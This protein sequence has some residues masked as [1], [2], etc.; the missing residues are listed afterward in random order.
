MRKNI[1]L[2]ILLSFIHSVTALSQ[3]ISSEIH[4]KGLVKESGENGIFTE[5]L[6]F[7]GAFTDI[8]TQLPLYTESISIGSYNSEINASFDSV[9][10][11]PCSAEESNYL[12]GI[13]FRDRDITINTFVVVDRKVPLGII[14]FLP[15][16]FNNENGN[17][18]KLIFYRIKI[19]VTA[20]SNYPVVKSRNYA[21]HSVLSS[22]QW[23]KIKTGKSGIY[24][25]GYNDL[26]SFG[27]DP[28]SVNPTMIR[29]FGNGG[30]MLPEA[31][32]KFRY[33]DLQE[34]AIQVIGE[35]DGVFNQGDYI[36]FYGMDPNVWQNVLGYF[37]YYVNYYDD[38]N[39]YYLT[40]S[41]EPGKRLQTV[42]SVASN[43]SNYVTKYNDY[44]VVEDEEINLIQSGKV[45]YGDVFGE[46]NNRE[47]QFNFP[48]IV[49]SDPVIIKTEVANRSFENELMALH[50]N[51]DLN[52]T[53]ILTL[54]SPSSTK[55]AQKKKKT[56]TYYTGNTDVNVKFEYLPST[57]SSIAWLNYIMV[58]ASSN[59]KFD[60]GQLMFRQLSSVLDGAVSEFTITNSNPG[61]MVWDITNPII[62]FK[63]EPE[64][65]AGELLFTVQTDSLREFVAFDGSEYYS[66]EFVE[67]VD[68]QDLHGDGP[69]D[70][71]I[72]SHPLFIDQANELAALH[73][74]RDSF[75]I[76]VVGT[77][78]IYNEFSS[79]KQDP[80]AIRD[81]MK[82]LYD[83]YEGNEP[84]F[85]VLFGDGSFDPKNRYENNSNFIPAFQNEESWITASSFVI[86]DFYGFLDENEGNDGVGQL[87]I[88]IGRFP[89]QT[90]EEAQTAIDK[91]NLYLA[92][93]EPVFGTWRSKICFIADDEDGN[94]HLE[95]ADSLANGAGFIPELYNEQK[96]YLDAYPQVKTPAGYRYPA[97]TEAINNAVNNGALI[98]NYVGHGGKAGWAHE[99]I[100][101]SNDI[102]DWTNV[103][104]MP[105]FITATCEFTRFDEPELS[106]GGEMVFLNP[107]GGGIALFTTT[108]L[109]YAQS[110]FTVNQRVLDAAFNLTDGEHPYLGDIIKHSKPP[111]QLTTR[112]FILVGDPALKMAYSTYNVRTVKILNKSTQMASDTLQ[113]L[114][115]I[116]AEGE[117]IDEAGNKITNFNGK[118]YITLYDKPTRYN[119]IG[120]DTYSY[121]I[122][123][124][125]QDK[126]IWTGEAT[127]T[128]GSFVFTFMM[129]K[130]I[131][132]EYGS[133]K[134]S[135]YSFSNDADAM[136]YN[137]EIIIGGINTN[138]VSDNEGPQ[139]DLFLN[140]LTFV[141]GDQTHENPIML[142]FI[143]DLSGINLSAGGIGHEILATL[144]NDYSNVIYLSEYYVQDIDSYQSGKIYYPFYNLPDGLHT[145]TL[146]AWDNYNNPAEKTIEFL[147]NQNAVLALNQVKNSPNPFKDQTTFSFDHNNPGDELDI[148]LDIFDL[149]G[150]IVL[151]YHTKIVT[152]STYTPFFIW[153]GNDGKG[154]KLKSGIYLYTLIVTDEQKAVSVQRQK[155]VLTD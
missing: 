151:N 69:F 111:G 125:C 82:M 148:T 16:R 51:N 55:Y 89:V 78:E 52:D 46:I 144:D 83:K 115:L 76:K 108:R 102:Q 49:T 143:N 62:P 87:D 31:N 54:V 75:E 133:G 128:A 24:K 32:D 73:V 130:D 74:S 146:K 107:H 127:V 2:F 67:M 72:V 34:N 7:E 14:S 50:V 66:P 154:N 45:W 95:Q 150:R 88:G 121:P 11:E 4:W 23:I 59:L 117:I 153:N 35:D 86:D 10:F 64:S 39:Y 40:I 47:Y 137:N 139:I 138:A 112:N 3:F 136:G 38:H 81:Y 109:A 100:L 105:V 140:D 43:P 93:T 103:G 1:L 84:R 90:V 27:I 85:L 92:T 77:K 104:K 12:S 79:G 18:E 113:A 145:L 60:N 20:N 41:A 129:P 36:L 68:N 8:P 94:L 6:Y 15:L 135:Y 57:L 91:I 28:A 131:A 61:L 65:N 48:N 63:I 25:I 152:E 149:A 13:Q 19:D 110:N 21:E 17:Y 116:Y 134:I 29:I 132:Y 118:V 9:L 101:G 122:T 99:R 80:T 26:E 56:L 119:T 71:V 126:K 155:L 33:D 70:M 96:I 5:Y 142:A 114:D 123:F 53:M 22:G 37:T 120:N 124:L 98:V 106:T 44:Q 30:G 42:L 58:N 97:V 141:S 147:I